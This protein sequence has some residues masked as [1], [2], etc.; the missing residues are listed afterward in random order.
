MKMRQKWNRFIYMCLS[1]VKEEWGVSMCRAHTF[2]TAAGWS[3]VEFL[4]NQYWCQPCLISLGMMW[5]RGLSAPSTNLQI[6]QIWFGSVGML[7]GKKSLQRVLRC[8]CV[9]RPAGILLMRSWPHRKAARQMFSPKPHQLYFSSLKLFPTA[10][11][12]E[13]F[14]PGFIFHFFLVWESNNNCPK[15]TRTK[16]SPLIK[17]QYKYNIFEYFFTFPC[18]YS[19]ACKAYLKLILF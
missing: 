11:I 14:L 6:R 15:S 19:L 13:G 1:A 16:E 8:G 9:S 18:V 3:Q 4:R 2:L 7:E 10:R 17:N 5:V 12:L